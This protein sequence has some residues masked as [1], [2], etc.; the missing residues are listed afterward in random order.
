MG[1]Y[2]RYVEAFSLVLCIGLIGCAAPTSALLPSVVVPI[3]DDRMGSFQVHEYALVEQS[4]DNP[5]HVE[6]QQH[7]PAAVVAR[8]IGWPFTRPEDAI[9]TPNLA[10]APFDFR[11]EV[12]PT[13][14]FSGYALYHDHL[15]IQRD[16]AVFWPVS[17]QKAK[18]SDSESDFLLSFE[19]M[20][21]EKLVASMAGIHPWPGQ[22]EPV[23]SPPP[24]YFGNQMA[25]AESVGSEFSIYA[26]SELLY[27]GAS[28]DEGVFGWQIIAGQ[29]FYFYNRGDIIH[30]HFADQDLAYTYD[31]VV[32]NNSGPIAIFNPGGAGR[33]GWFYALRDGVW[34][35]VEVGVFE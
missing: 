7:V 14:P 9:Q 16:I 17:L 32:H 23:G 21:G 6:F 8:R 34:Y 30:L 19:T 18:D 15:L 24:D 27:N 22:D 2:L 11:L 10:L 33:I 29:P 31:Q 13:P 25:Y 4:I 26:G 35:Y 3:D 1:R 5:N 28:S 12:N 20:D